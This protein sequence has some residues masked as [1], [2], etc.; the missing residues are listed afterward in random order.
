MSS[1]NYDNASLYILFYIKAMKF[2]FKKLNLYIIKKCDI[3]NSIL[4]VVA[5]DK[6][7]NV[8]CILW[9]TGINYF[10]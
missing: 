6:S 8:W 10:Q 4:L 2:N 1:I 5:L 9:M 3:K 7:F